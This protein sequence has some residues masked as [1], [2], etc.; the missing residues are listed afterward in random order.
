MLITLALGGP[1]RMNFA[2]PDAAPSDRL[3]V[4]LWHDARGW[5]VKYP[6]VNRAV[7][8]PLSI[9]LADDERE[10]RE[11]RAAQ[12]PPEPK[13]TAKPPRPKPR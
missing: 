13:P 5:N 4:I 12:G 11:E 2:D 6:G 9:H 3:N 10:E 8:F 1:P 7:F